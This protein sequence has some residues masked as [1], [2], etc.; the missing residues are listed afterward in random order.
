VET[1]GEFLPEYAM[2][3]MRVQYLAGLGPNPAV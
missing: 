2:L 3:H 1:I